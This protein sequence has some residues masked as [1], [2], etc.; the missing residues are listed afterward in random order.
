MNLKMDQSL[1]RGYIMSLMVFIQNIHVFNCRSEN[2]SLLK[3]PILSNKLIILGVVFSILLQIIVMEVSFL[4][5]SLKIVSVPF[6]NLIFLF[7]FSLSI[8]PFMEIYK[9]IH[10]L[11][12]K[13][14]P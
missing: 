3:V 4:A 6:I 12:K 5:N 1:A 7:I 14:N 10:S 8:I 13:K 11:I 9:K 2:K